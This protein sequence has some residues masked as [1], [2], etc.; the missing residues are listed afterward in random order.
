MVEKETTPA[1][2][3]T[4]ESL[5]QQWRQ[6][7]DLRVQQLE[8]WHARVR[9]HPQR[10]AARRE[11]I[12][13][14]SKRH[15]RSGSTRRR[16]KNHCRGK[17]KR[18]LLGSRL[19]RKENIRLHERSSRDRVSGSASRGMH[20]HGRTASTSSAPSASSGCIAK[21]SAVASE[22]HTTIPSHRKAMK[23]LRVSTR[24]R[25]SKA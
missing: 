21:G 23:G 4:R 9:R 11:T 12:R 3:E 6:G 7:R 8:K 2:K 18:R 5:A 1:Q 20:S 25:R 15:P 22:F 10:A 24:S 16:P 14:G 17:T 13:P 19:W